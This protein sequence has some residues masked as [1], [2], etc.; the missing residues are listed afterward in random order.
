MPLVFPVLGACIN[1]GAVPLDR[2]RR[3]RRPRS[4]GTAP[5]FMQAPSTGKTSGIGLASCAPV[6]YRR[7]W[8]VAN[9]MPLVF[10]LLAML[11]K[12]WGR[13]PGLRGTP[14]SRIRNNGGQRLAGCEQAD[15]GV[16]RGPG[17]PPHDLCRRPAPEKRV[18]LGWQPACRRLQM[19]D[20]R[21]LPAGAQIAKLSH[22]RTLLRGHS[23]SLTWGTG[24]AWHHGRESYS[25]THSGCLTMKMRLGMS[26]R[27]FIAQE[28]ERLPEQD[29]DRLMAFLRS[30]ADAHAEAAIPAAA[31]ESSL[32]KDWL[33]PEEDAAWASL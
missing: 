19:A 9:L 21:R 4:R 33:T 11:R 5:R 3:G 6:V 10:P 13:P 23:N 29:L 28:L 2:G 7:N 16:G 26:K 20:R 25:P 31:A 12:L 24:G 14:S 30:L 27:E 18:A 1:R 32:A 15:G 8:R 22:N 17:G